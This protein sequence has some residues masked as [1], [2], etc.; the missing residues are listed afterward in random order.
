MTEA[1]VED[2]VDNL[3]QD[4]VIFLFDMLYEKRAVFKGQYWLGELGE[5]TVLV[6]RFSVDVCRVGKHV[7]A[8]STA[9]YR[10]RHGTV[11]IIF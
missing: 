2:N 5:H 11:V 6:G 10:E 3:H 4:T 7:T 9:R 1:G 8:N